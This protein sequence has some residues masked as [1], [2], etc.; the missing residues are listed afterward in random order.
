MAERHLESGA[1]GYLFGM[2]L[3]AGANPAEIMF[4]GGEAPGNVVLPV[5]GRVVARCRSR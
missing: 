5:I 1:M 4:A 3:R 2:P